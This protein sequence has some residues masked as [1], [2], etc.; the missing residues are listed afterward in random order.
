MTKQEFISRHQAFKRISGKEAVFAVLFILSLGALGGSVGPL[1][2]Y[3]RSHVESFR[4]QHFVNG[5]VMLFSIAFIITGF[6]F[7]L[8]RVKLRMERFGLVCPGCGRQL[9]GGSLAKTVIAT[10]CCSQCGKKLIDE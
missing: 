1:A 5:I 3:L 7:M 9:I 10:G 4:L 2:A 8:R 6:A